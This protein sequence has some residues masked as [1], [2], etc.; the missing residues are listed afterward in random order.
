M[1][2]GE[3]RLSRQNCRGFSLK[4]EQVAQK[5]AFFYCSC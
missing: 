3:S 5:A 1:K 2:I 4:I